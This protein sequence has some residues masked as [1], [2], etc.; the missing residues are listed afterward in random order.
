M[1]RAIARALGALASIPNKAIKASAS[2][3][4]A[5]AD[6]SI[7]ALSHLVG[8]RGG[9]RHVRPSSICRAGTLRAV[10]RAI[11]SDVVWRAPA[12]E[13]DACAGCIHASAMAIAVVH[14]G[15][16]PADSSDQ[17]QKTE[18]SQDGERTNRSKSIQNEMMTA[19]DETKPPETPDSQISGLLVL[20]SQC[21]CSLSCKYSVMV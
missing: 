9:Q 20:G 8:T 6:A 2:S 14:G 1:A 12:I 4:G 15:A 10:R 17:N 5:V 7:R 16:V 21:Y 13:A 3:S 19:A 18:G 11:Q